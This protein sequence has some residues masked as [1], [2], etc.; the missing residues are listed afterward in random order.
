MTQIYCKNYGIYA[1]KILL[2]V[3]LNFANRGAGGTFQIKTGDLNDHLAT[4]PPPI[5]SAYFIGTV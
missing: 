5:T 4:T 2:G 3:L 1:L